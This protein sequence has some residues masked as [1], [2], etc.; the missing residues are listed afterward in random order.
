MIVYST[1]IPSSFINL[2][3]T[4]LKD[5]CH[6]A[7]VPPEGRHQQ[8]NQSDREAIDQ[9][10][11]RLHRVPNCQIDQHQNS[12]PFLR[13]ERQLLR[14]PLLIG[15]HPLQ[16]LT[17]QRSYEAQVERQCGHLLYPHS[18]TELPYNPLLV[19]CFDGLIE[20]KHPYGFI[21][22]NVSK[23]MIED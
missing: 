6:Q 2:N 14:T 18:Q 5:R 22:Y 8:A 16:D 21:A 12:R 13:K 7:H 4:S 11:D 1:D 23:E 20:E 9:T 19:T 10:Q 3:E 17:R 15:R